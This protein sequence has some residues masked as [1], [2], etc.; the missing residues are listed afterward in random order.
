MAG[1]HGKQ[2]GDSMNENELTVVNYQEVGCYSDL[3]DSIS[4]YVWQVQEAI[5]HDEKLRNEVA[6]TVAGKMVV[7]EVE[8]NFKVSGINIVD[9]MELFLQSPRLSTTTKS[10]YRKWLGNYLSWCTTKNI[11]CRK[12]TRIEAESY[13]YTLNCKYSPASTRCMV[14]SVSSFYTF[15]SFRY[16]DIVNNPFYK[17]NLPKLKEPKHDV[18]TFEDLKV[19]RKYFLN[20][21]RKDFVCAIEILEKYGFRVGIFETMTIDRNGNWTAVSKEQRK[22]G[23]FT[24]GEIK[25]LLDSGLL[26]MRKCTIANKIRKV[27]TLL[28]KQGKISCPFS[29]H[30]IRHYRIT[31]DMNNIKNGGDIYAVSKK[32]H[33]NLNTTM[34]YNTG[35]I[36]KKPGEKW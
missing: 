27:T 23:K 1:N 16:F 2:I 31:D 25:M 12:T 36:V 26:K 10:N 3:N 17:L 5:P 29:V 15:L 4:G 13:L 9:E 18:V 34:G 22:S 20:L 33:K 21:K 11:D 8:H 28:Y 24:K 30:D 19:V 7:E 14:L 6:K 32:Y 35:K